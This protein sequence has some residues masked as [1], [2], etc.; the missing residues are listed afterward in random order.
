MFGIRPSLTEIRGKAALFHSF[1]FFRTLS[2]NGVCR[3]LSRI[4]RA[5]INLPMAEAR[6][7]HCYSH[8]LENLGERPFLVTMQL[9]ASSLKNRLFAATRVNVF[10]V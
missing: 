9:Y 2:V 7:F 3:T 8:V 4:D 6:D 1:F 5:F 10:Q